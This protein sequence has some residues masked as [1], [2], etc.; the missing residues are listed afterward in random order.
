VGF[1]KLFECGVV[2]H[3]KIVEEDCY[4]SSTV[5][6]FDLLNQFAQSFKSNAVISEHASNQLSRGVN[7]C[8]GPNSCEAI[9]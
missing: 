4:L 3:A 7:C 1:Y 5:I 6:L 8:Y 9:F 2:M